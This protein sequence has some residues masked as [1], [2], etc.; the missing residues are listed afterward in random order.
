MNRLFPPCAERDEKALS[1]KLFGKRLYGDQTLGEYMLE[2]LL[3]FASAKSA[4]GTGKFQF[5][6][7]EQIENDKLAYYTI[8][9]NSLKRFVFYDRSKRESKS[10][11]DTDAYNQMLADLR[12]KSVDDDDYPYIIQDL[13]YGYSLVIKKRGWYAQSLTPVAPEL[14]FPE[15]L[16][17][18]ER[19][20]KEYASPIEVETAFEYGQHDFLA[21]GGE[22]YYLFLLNGIYASPDGA[23]YKEAI[24]RGVEHMLCAKS[25]GFSVIANHL[26]KWALENQGIDESNSKLTRKMTMGY[27]EDGFDRR[28]VRGL[29]EL[30]TFLSNEIHPIKRIELITCGIALSLLRSMHLQAFYKVHDESEPEPAWIIDMHSGTATSNIAKLAA[31]SYRSAY[32]EFANALNII[33]EDED[34]DNKFTEVSAELKNT[35]EVFKKIGKEIQLVIPPKGNY[36]RF[37]LSEDLVKYLVLSLVKP[38][39]K[40]TFDTFLDLLYEH[41]GMVIGPAQYAKV[42]GKTGMS[43]YFEDNKE[44]FQLFLKNCGLLRDLSDATS[45]IE[46]QY[47]EVN[48]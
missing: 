28:S 40:V 17:I 45:I 4:D 3:V 43:G 30:A 23:Q 25:T 35:S 6:T 9:R 27:L 14:L 10:D 13:L 7:T 47:P 24:E 20:K 31:E 16:G 26:Q 15:T 34:A 33:C 1:I 12:K 39:T 2:F 5:H 38:Q 8:P 37:S 32:A 44:C 11:I 21:R 48:Y 18:N 29:K 19:K 42:T 41:Y 22:M 46:N 36:E